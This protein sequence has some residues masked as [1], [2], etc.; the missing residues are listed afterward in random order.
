MRRNRAD[1]CLSQSLTVRFLVQNIRGIVEDEPCLS[2]WKQ[3]DITEKKIFTMAKQQQQKTSTSITI[4]GTQKC[5]MCSANVT[6][7][8]ILEKVL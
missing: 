2:D 6:R 4:W 8:P 3:D 7:I 1:K 5:I